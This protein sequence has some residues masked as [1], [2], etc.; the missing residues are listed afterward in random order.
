MKHYPP[1][2]RRA[3]AEVFLDIRWRETRSCR[4]MTAALG[5]VMELAARQA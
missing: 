1:S 5:S 3:A 2:S 4:E